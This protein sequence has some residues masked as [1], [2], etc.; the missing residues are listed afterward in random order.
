MFDKEWLVKLLESLRVEELVRKFNF[1]GSIETLEE[2]IK[3][4]W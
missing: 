2:K 1:D 4:H 3:A